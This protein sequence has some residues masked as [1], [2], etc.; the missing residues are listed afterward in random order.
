MQHDSRGETPVRRLRLVIRI[1]SKHD[2]AWRRRSVRLGSTVLLPPIVSCLFILSAY[3][4]TVSY[5]VVSTVGHSLVRDL[6]LFMHLDPRQISPI[7]L[8]L[9]WNPSC[10]STSPFDLLP[11]QKYS[12]TNLS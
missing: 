1:P 5:F 11:N 3:K 4:V 10:I 7:K 6:I 2:V 8:F 9:H 12:I